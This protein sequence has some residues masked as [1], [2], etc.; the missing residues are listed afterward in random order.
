MTAP[1]RRLLAAA[2]VLAMTGLAPAAFAPAAQAADVDNAQDAVRDLGREVEIAAEDHHEIQVRLGERQ[3][4]AEAAQARAS[5]Q[6]RTIEAIRDEL[7]ALA[8]ETFKRGGVDPQL[9][10]L[11][12][13]AGDYGSSTAA[14]TV[15]AERRSTSLTDLKEA[16]VELEQLQTSAQAELDE[17]AALEADLDQRSQ[18]IQARLA[19]AEGVLADAEAEAARIQAA[20]TEAAEQATRSREAAAAAAQAAAAPVGTDQVVPRESAPAQMDPTGEDQVGGAPAEAAAAPGASG[21]ITCDGFSVQAPNARAATVLAFACG[22]LG[23]PYSFGASG[24]NAYD[25]SGFTMAAWSQVGVALPHSSRAQA[26]VGT[27][28]SQGDLLPGD[29]VFSFSPISHVGIYLG[30][31]RMVAAPTAGDVVKIQYLQYLPFTAGTRL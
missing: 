13:G 15:M 2:I 19:D 24:P 1:S 12:G 8:V 26:G 4:Q 5:S 3:Q 14:L 28:L 7:G 31:G 21:T 20:R 23:K 30:D 16:Q 9:A 27:P 25:C 18:D 11:V 6:A 22:E 10:A 29:L 17:V